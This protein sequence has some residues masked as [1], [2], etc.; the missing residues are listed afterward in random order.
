MFGPERLRQSFALRELVRETTLEARDLVLP[1]FVNSEKKGTK[2]ISSMPGV[3]Q[4]STEALLKFGE[5]QVKNGLRSFIFFGIVPEHQKSNSGEAS[6]DKNGP[7]AKAIQ[8]FRKE[9]GN[10]VNL[11]ADACFCEYTDHGHCGVFEKTKK[12]FVRNFE[13]TH[14]NLGKQAIA[15]A[16]MGANVVAPSGMLDGMVTTIRSALDKSKHQEVAVCAYAVKY[17]S[18]FYGPFREAAE[19]S[20]LKGTDR[21]SYQMDPANTREAIK[22]AEL[23]LAEG[24][25]MLLVK[26]AMSYLD[27]VANVAAMSPVPVGC[28]QVSGEYAALMGA[29]Q[30]GWLNENGVFMESLLSMKRAGARFIL[31]YW[32]PQAAELLKKNY[33]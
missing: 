7:V 4:W 8:M 14:E 3:N 31:S 30:K 5:V 24:A 9:F 21:K 23:D 29:A 12:G 27:I 18:S 11:I 32:A 6:T 15:Y 28:Y 20:P 10:D 2:A 13:K 33:L 26:P 25:D 19:N 17:A 1:V 22:E 16:Q